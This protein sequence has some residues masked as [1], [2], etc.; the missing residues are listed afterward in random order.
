LRAARE[1]NSKDR[2]ISFTHIYNEL[3]P[4]ADQLAKEAVH[5]APGTLQIEHIVEGISTL[6]SGQIF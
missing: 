5:V 2:K 3:K 1:K 4:E 6:P